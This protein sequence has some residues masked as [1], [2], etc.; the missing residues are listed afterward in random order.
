MHRAVR[1]ACRSLTLLLLLA[2][3]CHAGAADGT[4]PPPRDEP[5]P[6]IVRLQVDA[7]DVDRRLVRVEQTLPVASS[8]PLTLLYPRWLPGNNSTTGPIEQLAGLQVTTDRGERV[9]WE[10][11]ADQLHAFHLDVP[12]GVSSL[13][14]RFDF[15]SPTSPE[16]GRQVMTQDVLGLQWEKALLYPAG[17]AASRITYEA[18]LTLP[19]GW[20]YA[21][22]LEGQRQGDTVRFRATTLEQLVDSPVFAGRHHRMIELDSNPAAPVRLQVFADR[23]AELEARPEQIEVHR[24]MVA[25]TLAL[26]GTRHYRHYDFLL[27]ISNQ[28]SPIGLEHHESSEN[29]VPHGYFIDWFGSAPVRDL[30]AHEFVHSWNGKFRRPAGLLTPSFEVPLRGDLLWAYEGLSEYWGL[31]LAAR[32]GLWSQAYFRDTLAM[33]AATA[34]HGRP[35]RAWRNLQDTMHQSVLL[36]RGTQGYPSWQRAKDYYGEGALLWLDIDTRIREL[37][38][39]KRSLDDFARAFFGIEN[40]RLVPIAFTFEDIVAAL[41]AVAPSDW[42]G[43]LRS[44]LDGH[45]PGAPL[46]GLT[47]GGWRLAYRDTPGEAVAANDLAGRHD[48]FLFSLGLTIDRSSV[49]TE[50]TWDSPAFKAGLAPRTVVVAVDGRA[51]NPKL[52]R[53]AIRAAAIDKAR[54]IAL[55]VRRGD[56]YST[57]EI[58]YHGGL[59][60]PTLERI[61]E[62]ED[63]LG[64]ITTP[65][66][67]GGAGR[68]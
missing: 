29:A 3:S 24:R 56:T 15:I 33:Y 5:Y 18:S 11:D 49:I 27:A 63:R 60:Y 14:L 17:H 26:F 21:T 38:R 23:P 37:T 35:G 12:P 61:E 34:E 53:E 32:S 9:E 59:R 44:R 42:A 39:D 41:D 64:V 31:V 68:S 25:E 28:F 58:D 30:L 1:T 66:A 62:R 46:D 50:V 55:L 22:S 48:A 67:T 45:G 47:R 40:G 13:Q 51:Y 4:I 2:T 10:R 36:Y 16:Q 57:V 52:L 8:G 7:S 54:K 43:F 19:T 6:G 65:R 20:A